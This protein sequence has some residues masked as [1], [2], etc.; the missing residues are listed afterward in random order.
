MV[1]FKQFLESDRI[2]HSVD[3]VRQNTTQK[4]NANGKYDWYTDTDIRNKSMQL[5]KVP[6]RR[7]QMS[8]LSTEYARRY[9]QWYEGSNSD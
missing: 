2:S 1:R 8:P 5:V 6:M 3:V 9:Q 4:I 7:T